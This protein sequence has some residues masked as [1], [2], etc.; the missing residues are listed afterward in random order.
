MSET[1][2]NMGDTE[3]PSN[4]EKV[5]LK[6]GYH[7]LTVTGFECK[8]DDGKTP[9]II[10]TAETQAKE[11]EEAT[12]FT[13]NFWMSGKLN[14]EGKMSSVIRLQELAMGL[15]G[16][17]IT[18]QPKIVTYVK[19][20]KDGTSE[21]YSIPNPEE[22]TTWFNKHCKGKV[23]IFKIGG[24]ESDGKVYS[25]LTY[26]SFLYYTDKQKNLCRYKEE[27]DFTESEYKYSVQKKKEASAPAGGGG[28]STLA[29]MEDM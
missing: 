25:K 21:T 24:E 5:Y 26:S 20:E 11:G 18:I 19:K 9:V 28:V 23:G 8:S 14:K 27:R 10:I 1:S 15:T 17:K 12:K 7:K 3:A 16:N 2:Y 6:P 4:E 29:K 22:L 13:D